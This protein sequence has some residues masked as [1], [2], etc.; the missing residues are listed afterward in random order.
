MQSLLNNV[1]PLDPVVYASVAALF[2]VVAVLA[3]LV[4]SMRASRIDPLQA[5]GDRNG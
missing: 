4:P 1:Q 5:L 2:S 3:C